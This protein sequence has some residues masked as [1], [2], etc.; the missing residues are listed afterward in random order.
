MPESPFIED[1]P[2]RKWGIE[3]EILP[4]VEVGVLLRAT[5]TA[6]RSAGFQTDVQS[7]HYM[8]DG[9]ENT[10]WKW[11][12]DGSCG[13][14]LVSPVLSG[15]AGLRE[16]QVMMD[17]VDREGALRGGRL[18]D[19]RCGVHVHI[20]CRDHSA[21]DI[22]KLIM[23]MKIWEPLFFAM[24]PHSRSSN[25]YC[26]PLNTDCIAVKNATGRESIKDAWDNPRTSGGNRYHGLNLCPWWRGGSVEFRYFSGTWAFEKAAGAI[27]MSLLFV[28]AVKRK[29]SVRIPDPQLQASYQSI[30]ELAGRI[31]F[32]EYSEKFFRDFLAMR[33]NANPALREFK[34]YVKSRISTFYENTG[35]RKRIS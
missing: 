1:L 24:N 7:S 16:L 22:K 6:L 17:T 21:T 18:V 33:S 29:E 15:W 11:K 5:K 12:P 10:V 8:H 35:A 14:E 28:D 3:L 23:A 20:D 26:Q 19:S 32:E 30:W 27:L 2:P 4:S 31:G 13:N 9:P 25:H 34:K